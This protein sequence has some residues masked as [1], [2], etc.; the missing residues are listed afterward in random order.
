[1]K[2]IKSFIY[3]KLNNEI[4]ELR[5]LV[6][7]FDRSKLFDNNYNLNDSVPEE[8]YDKLVELSNSNHPSNET[9]IS[10]WKMIFSKTCIEPMVVEIIGK[11]CTYSTIEQDRNEK[12]DI[13]YHNTLIDVKN[14]LSSKNHNYSL[15]LDDIDFIK[16]KLKDGKRY[17]LFLDEEIKTWDYFIQVYKRKNSFK[18]YMISYNDLNDLIENNDYEVKKS[19]KKEYILIPENDIKKNDKVRKK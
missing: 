16:S 10:I 4:E 1:M 11:D 19:G 18:L 8:F 5:N 2:D 12:W 14:T 17:I 13:K 7:K 3:E 15:S 6:K 9:L